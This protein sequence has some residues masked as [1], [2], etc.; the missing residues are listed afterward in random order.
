MINTYN[1][2]DKGLVN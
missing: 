2:N 1:T